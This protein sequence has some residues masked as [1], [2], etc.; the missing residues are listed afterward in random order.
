MILEAYRSMA[1][2]AGGATDDAALVEA[3][4]GVV[5]MVPGSPRNIKITHPHDI[6]LAEHFLAS[7]GG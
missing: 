6:G 3:C 2:L 4:G 5:R 1:G 7:E